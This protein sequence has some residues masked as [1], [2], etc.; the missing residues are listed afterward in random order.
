M[1]L[2]AA[3]A[4]C[5]GDASRSAD[6]PKPPTPL[7]L[8]P[9][10]GAYTGSP[11]ARGL[12]PARPLFTWAPVRVDASVTYELEV[13]DDCTPA[14]LQRCAFRSPSVRASVV[15]GSAWRPARPLPISDRAPVGRRYYWRVRACVDGACSAWSRVRY[16]EVGRTG[17]DLNGDGYSDVAVAAPLIDGP[18]RADAD[19]GAVFVYY[20]GPRGVGDG[21]ELRIDA[22]DGGAGDAFGV[23]LAIA[24]DVDADGYADLLA[25]AA[26][27][28]EQRGAAYLFLGGPAGVGSEPD[29]RF[30][31][32][33]G[34]SQDW[35]GSSVAGVGDVDGDGFPDIVIGASGV[36]RGG[37]DWGITFLY[38]GGPIG[39]RPWRVQEIVAL[40]PRDFDHFGF[41]IARAGDVNSDGYDDIAIGSPGI[42]VAGDLRGVDRGAAYVFPGGPHGP[43]AIPLARLEAPV[44]LD[45][46]RFGFAV[47]GAGDI[48]GDGYDDIAVG[49]PGADS[50][51]ADGGAVYLFT[52]GPTGISGLPASVLEDPRARVFDRFG[53]SLSAAGD[54][55]A[56]GYGDLVV[57]ASGV[58]RGR[59][60]VF[61]GGP[62]GASPI[63]RAV[64]HDPLGPGYN[65]FADAVAGAGDVDGDGYDD[66]LIGASGSDNGGT[67]RGSVVLYAG[68][69]AGIDARYPVRMDNPD[70]GIH[71][72]FGHDV[73]GR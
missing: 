51:L 56:D 20:G 61:H 69:A 55:D 26:G 24:G 65:H 6:G 64:L 38:P 7:P 45:H 2:L 19:R 39:P 36:D 13:D 37:V 42:D 23:A 8:T 62:E 29:V 14:G 11:H 32:D 27:A 66:V 3:L 17:G 72:H 57:G 34:D 28:D 1:P 71:D 44:P 60:L 59:G 41:A 63:P 47:S 43:S 50:A 73:A 21:G 53:I 18:R 31:H 5:S 4:A 9:A 58:D 68:T 49:A 52:G 30:T 70:T 16:V 15:D 67:F 40:E 22:P 25:G 12:D 35:F 10:N 48:D 33:D 54:V 46:D